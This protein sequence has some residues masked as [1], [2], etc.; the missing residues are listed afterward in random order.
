M[1]EIRVGSTAAAKTVDELTGTPYEWMLDLQASRWPSGIPRPI[2]LLLGNEQLTSNAVDA[3]RRKPKPPTRSQDEE[4]TKRQSGTDLSTEATQVR[5]RKRLSASYQSDRCV[6][7]N[8]FSA[9]MENAEF[10]TG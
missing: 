8:R 7:G 6:T 2:P 1:G 3:V 5:Q 4:L 10:V 9:S